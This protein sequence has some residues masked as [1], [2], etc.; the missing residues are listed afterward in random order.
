MDSEP[1]ITTT[2][3]AEVET[4]QIDGELATPDVMIPQE[5][6]AG[7]PG[8]TIEITRRDFL[9]LGGL[10]AAVGG[11]G[12]M[13]KLS[14]PENHSENPIFIE[15]KKRKDE[16]SKYIEDFFSKYEVNPADFPTRGLEKLVNLDHECLAAY[17]GVKFKIGEFWKYIEE[18]SQQKDLPR[19][20][21]GAIANQ[22][23]ALFTRTKVPVPYGMV[24]TTYLARQFMGLRYKYFQAYDTFLEKV[25]L[26]N[27]DEVLSAKGTT[28][29]YITTD[30][31]CGACMDSAPSMAVLSTLASEDVKIKKAVVP[32]GGRAN[33]APLIVKNIQIEEFPT[34]VL[35]IDGKIS[36]MMEGGK[37]DPTI[38]RNFA[39]EAALA[40]QK[41]EAPY[42]ARGNTPGMPTIGLYD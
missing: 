22:N 15:C 12:V 33:L 8:K 7:V 18:V 28:L 16:L 6:E 5:N 40:H 13:I 37:T 35:L 42:K 9:A 25:E 26:D 30:A 38:V 27:L 1:D 2:E 21:M 31:E 34:I 3:Q 17:S 36:G 23:D 32:H 14:E 41:G 39:R 20:I 24:Y 11:L 29:L 19:G 4:T 10:L